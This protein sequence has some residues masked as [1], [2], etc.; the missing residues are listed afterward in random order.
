MNKKE[1]QEQKQ[2]TVNKKGEQEQEQER[3]KREEAGRALNNKE[4][5]KKKGRE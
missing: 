4:L 5:E 3:T 2:E 1:E